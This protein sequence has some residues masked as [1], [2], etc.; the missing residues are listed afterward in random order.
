M[1]RALAAAVPALF[2]LALPP[3]PAS[4]QKAVFVVRHGEKASDAS[5]AGTPL[6][7]AGQKRAQKLAVL[8]QDAGITAVY[9]TDTVRT[10]TTAQPLASALHV[11][12]Q[13][14]D[15]KDA[16]GKVSAAAVLERLQKE[17]QA[18]V[19]VVGHSN[20]VP[21]LLSALGVPG[22]I[23]IGDQDY[24]NLFLVVPRA[25]GEPVFLRLKF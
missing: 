1:K 20:T 25:A 11:E 13:I 6:S 15:P 4:A 16:Q 3:A 9:S 12:T 2:L 7:E 17:P 14:Y 10:R 22:K 21:L 8:L 23:E 18:V 24:D 5:E 19:L